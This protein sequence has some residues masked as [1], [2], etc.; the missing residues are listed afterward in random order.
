MS[1]VEIN[2][3]PER[4]E[5]RKFGVIAL[6]VLTAVSVVL[7]FVFK[8][9]IVVPACVFTAGFCIF[10]TTL[11]S[12]KAARIIYLGLTFAAMPVGFVISVVLMAVFYYLVLTPVGLVFRLLGRDP[13]NRRFEPRAPTYWTPRRRVDSVERYFHQF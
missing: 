13:L 10:V 7:R 2:W 8:A 9:G 1:L 3:N 5:L 11:V 12:A 6:V 4:S